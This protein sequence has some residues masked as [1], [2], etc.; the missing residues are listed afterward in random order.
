MGE[1]Y[2]W[3]PWRALGLSPYATENGEILRQ[4][5]GESNLRVVRGLNLLMVNE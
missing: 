5:L 2:H 1:S 4:Q 3:S